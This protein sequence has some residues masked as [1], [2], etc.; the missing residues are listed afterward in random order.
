MISTRNY[1]FYRPEEVDLL[2]LEEEEWTV[3][4][5]VTYVPYPQFCLLGGDVYSEDH[6]SDS[7]EQVAANASDWSDAYTL[8]SMVSREE[9]ADLYLEH[10]PSDACLSDYDFES[11][12]FERSRDIVGHYWL[13]MYGYDEPLCRLS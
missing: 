13:L 7:L 3:T 11:G 10:G 2:L 8:S 9:A 1:E 4:V 6:T 12:D 5:V